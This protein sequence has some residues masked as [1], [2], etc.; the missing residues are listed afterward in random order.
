M[1]AGTPYTVCDLLIFVEQAADAVMPLGPGDLGRRPVGG[2]REEAACP[3]AGVRTV[4]VVVAIELVQ[5]LTTVPAVT[6]R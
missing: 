2:G 6:A 1:H 4:M 3:Q 5:Q